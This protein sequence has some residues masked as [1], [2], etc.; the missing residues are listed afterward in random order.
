MQNK[1]S[2]P[3]YNTSSNDHLREILQLIKFETCKR[4]QF[5][6]L[7]K[8]I[9]HKVFKN[10]LLS[11]RSQNVTQER[12]F[13]KIHLKAS[14]F[15]CSY[16]SLNSTALLILTVTFWRDYNLKYYKTGHLNKIGKVSQSTKHLQ[17]TISLKNHN[18]LKL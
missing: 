17:A 3:L 18:Y 9:K 1:K 5:Y 15:L 4:N 6:K 8:Q 11:K 14:T 10:D 13:C 12:V 16:N 7:S 2:F